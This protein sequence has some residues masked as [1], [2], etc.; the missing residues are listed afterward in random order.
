MKRILAI[1]LAAVLLFGTAACTGNAGVTTVSPNT[2]VPT[3]SAPT[4]PP[5]MI[6]VTLDTNGGSGQVTVVSLPA[7]ASYGQLPE[8]QREDYV[9][10]GWFTDPE[11]GQLVTANMP[12]VCQANHTLYAHWQP[13]TEFTLTLD[14]NG[15]RI[16][17]YT[18]QMTVT[19]DKTYGTLPEPILEGYAFLGWFTDPQA[20]ERIDADTVCTSG[21]DHTLYA[22]W[23]YDPVAYWTHVLHS[24]VQTIPQ[25]R[26]VVVYLE[27][28]NNYKTFLDSDFLADAGAINPAEDLKSENITDDWVRSVD[29][30]VIIKLSSNIYMGAVNKV[31]MQRRFA[32]ME[33]YIFSV[34]AVNGGPR[35]QLYYR[36]QLAKILYPEYFKDVDMKAVA[37]ELEINPRVY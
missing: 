5:K 27:Q 2:T 10:L 22:H 35:L 15:G 4:Q 11:G 14:P 12:L 19:R 24:R 18:T 33:I 25:C 31:A 1:F 9:F 16:S 3:G 20:G 37:A 8:A 13:R 28:S 6:S 7:D 30:Y 32:D 23:E 21:E 17:P 29:P 36:L 34:S 26:R